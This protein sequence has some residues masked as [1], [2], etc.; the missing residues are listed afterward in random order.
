MQLKQL[1]YPQKYAKEMPLMRKE[2]EVQVEQMKQLLQECRQVVS[3][4]TEQK[5]LRQFLY[6]CNKDTISVDNSHFEHIV[7]YLN[8]LYKRYDYVYLS[9]IGSSQNE[10]AIDNNGRSRQKECMNKERE[11]YILT[12]RCWYKEMLTEKKFP[13]ILSPVRDTSG[14]Y[15]ISTVSEIH[16]A[17]QES[18]GIVGIDI[19]IP[20][21]V[22]KM[23]TERHC[24]LLTA[25][26]EIIYDSDPIANGAIHR[27]Y[28]IKMLLDKEVVKNIL[29][30]EIGGCESRYDNKKILLA[31][32]PII[33]NK[34]YLLFLTN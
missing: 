23:N 31:Y 26:G 1:H 6:E 33:E 7:S 16:N 19:T 27:K 28:N 15:I 2:I 24:I 18:M 14:S 3:K 30:N 8:G 5:E 34:Y 29:K 13:A 32:A 25:D 4:M 17:N 20:M 11:K 10:D 22:K 9:Y 12:E 21:L